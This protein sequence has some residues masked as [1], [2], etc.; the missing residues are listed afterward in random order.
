MNSNDIISKDQ[1][2]TRLLLEAGKIFFLFQQLENIIELCCV[3]LQVKGISITINDL[4]SDKSK[5]RNYT[6]GQMIS[7]MKGSMGFKQ[8]F[9]ERI[10]EF[11]KE[12][13]TF[14]HDYWIKNGVYALDQLIDEIT[15]K[16]IVSYEEGLYNE[17]TYLI[18]VFL[19]FNYSIGAEIAARDGKTSEFETDP[20]FSDMKQHVPHFLSVMEIG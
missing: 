16:E 3:F 10:G 6:L 8:S 7:G 4:F 17:T 13:N 14:I 12:R 5:R 18:Q 20:I 15:F 11:V 2:L 1:S 9:D 19:G